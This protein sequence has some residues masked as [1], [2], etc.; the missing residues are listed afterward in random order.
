M[1]SKKKNDSNYG[2]LNLSLLSLFLGSI[3][4]NSS[5]DA[6]DT[7]K[8]LKPKSTIGSSYTMLCSVRLN[9]K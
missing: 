1:S 2:Q 4:G 6:S 3:L 7:L 9:D 8:L 5:L